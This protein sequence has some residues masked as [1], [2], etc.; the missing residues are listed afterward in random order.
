M[1]RTI[2]LRRAAIAVAC[3]ITVIVGQ[4]S[5]TPWR[6]TDAHA[7]S[8]REEA[9]KHFLEGKRLYDAGDYNGAIREYKLAEELAPSPLND[10]NIGYAYDRL[11]DKA[12]A[13]KHYRSYVDRMPNAKDRETV[14]ARASKLEAELAADASAKAAAEE[15][16][17]KAEEARRAEEEAKRAAEEAARRQPPVGDPPV[18]DPPVGDPPVDTRPAGPAPTGDAE[19]D[20]AAA[21]DVAAMRD[22]S[23]M[24]P[25][26][27]GGS[28]HETFGQPQPPTGGTTGGAVATT[29]A[30]KQKPIYKQWWF[31]VVVGVS[32]FI[33]LDIATNDEPETGV[34]ARA[35]GGSTA[36][37]TVFT[38]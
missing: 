34:G 11:G 8:A 38:F 20:R 3:A 22:R 7:Q 32:A 12:N 19:L 4:L 37:A 14:L 9:K 33:L 35:P 5:A 21:I 10:Y 26:T 6:V 18:G 15:E 23:G 31:W 17:R 16:A 27:G 28:S 29:D 24:T 1:M 13:A 30:P 25:P 36:G 2:L